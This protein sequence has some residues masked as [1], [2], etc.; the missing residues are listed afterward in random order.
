[1]VRGRHF[2]ALACSCQV[3]LQKDL[4]SFLQEYVPESW[5]GQGRPQSRFRSFILSPRYKDAGCYLSCGRKKAASGSFGSKVNAT[6]QSKCF[7]LFQQFLQVFFCLSRVFL[8]SSF[9]SAPYQQPLGKGDTLGEKL[10]IDN[11]TITSLLCNTD[12]KLLQF[13]QV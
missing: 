1:M 11:E 10:L 2:C 12:T 6:S 9:Y 8:S 7:P 13:L 3:I 5:K 4:R